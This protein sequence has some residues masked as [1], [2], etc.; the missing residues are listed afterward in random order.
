LFW[1]YKF[2]QDMTLGDEEA[3][4][5]MDVAKKEY[6]FTNDRAVEYTDR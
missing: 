6:F 4:F 1:N 2:N 3:K 5:W